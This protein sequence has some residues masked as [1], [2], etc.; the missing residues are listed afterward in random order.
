MLSTLFR[1][2]EVPSG[3]L[4]YFQSLDVAEMVVNICRMYFVWPLIR[5]EADRL[6]HAVPEE[7]SSF[8]KMGVQWHDRPAA[9]CSG[10]KL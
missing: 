1:A 6:F 8:H 2:T 9:Q 10:T 7:S 5:C 3:L 4:M